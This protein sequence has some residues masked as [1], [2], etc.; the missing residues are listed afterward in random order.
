MTVYLNTAAERLS[1]MDYSFKEDTF[2]FTFKRPQKISPD[3]KIGVEFVHPRIDQVAQ[4]RILQEFSV[5][6]M[7]VDGEPSF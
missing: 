5:K 3:E 6:K 7:L 4:Q 2:Q 1:L